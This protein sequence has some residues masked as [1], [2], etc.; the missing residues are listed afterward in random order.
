MKNTKAGTFKFVENWKIQKVDSVTGEVLE[1]REFC[2]AIV[3]SGLER[4]ARMCMGDS[5]VYFRALV[6]GTGSTAVTTSD[7]ALE[8]EFTRELAT[9]SYE[10][11]CI[12]KFSKTFTFG[13]G[14]SES[15]T[16]A[17]ILDNET[18]GGVMLARTVFPAIEVS[19][20]IDLI[21]NAEITFARV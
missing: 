15:I 19:S 5:A 3:D 21:F 9:L 6:I 8:T 1:T 20:S 17:G 14:V 10:A 7:T 18:S 11:D 4:M 16:E 2:N 12:A 13:S